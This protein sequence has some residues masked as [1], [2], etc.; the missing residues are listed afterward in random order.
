MDRILVAL[1]MEPSPLEI[2][3]LRL[4]LRGLRDSASQSQE[5]S[6]ILDEITQMGSHAEPL[7]PDLIG[8]MKRGVYMPTVW[9]VPIIANSKSSELLKAALEQNGGRWPLN[10]TERCVLMKAGFHQFQEG[11]AEELFQI[12]ERDDEPRRGEILDSLVE[13]GTASV[14]EVLRVIDYRTAAR[15]P[16]LNA[17]LG[18]D[19]PLPA[20]IAQLSRGEHLEARKEFLTKVRHAIQLIEQR[21]D[22]VHEGLGSEKRPQTNP[23]CEPIAELLQRCEDS[24]LEFKAALRWDHAKAAVEPKNEKRVLQTIAGFANANGGT[25]LIGVDPQKK[26]VGLENDYKSFKGD[27]DDFERHLRNLVGSRLDRVLSASGMEVFFHHQGEFEICRV[28]VK[29]ASDPIFLTFGSEQEFWVRR[30][31][32]NARL[33][34]DDFTRYLQKRFKR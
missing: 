34:L 11:L 15:I 14:L 24:E 32:A 22:P 1:D 12:F 8:T 28:V 27:R 10:T 23:S 9:F 6:A 20:G 16:E 33:Q 31:N 21:P 13:A 5:L 25:L 19:G 3:N 17:E 29:A 4:R 7:V 18:S 30:G 26:I 2:S